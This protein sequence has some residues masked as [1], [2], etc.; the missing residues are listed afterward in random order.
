[1]LQFHLA[2]STACTSA[3]KDCKLSAC[4]VQQWG[5]EFAGVPERF[6][7]AMHEDWAELHKHMRFH[8]QFITLIR[9]HAE[10]V[11]EDDKVIKLYEDHCYIGAGLPP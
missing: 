10:W 1:M 3:G 11:A 4:S 9:E 6:P 2:L 7:L 8:R 5:P